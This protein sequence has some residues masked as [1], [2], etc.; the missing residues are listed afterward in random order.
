MCGLCHTQIDATGIYRRADYLAGGMRVGAYPHGTYVTYNLTSDVATGIGGWSG[1]QLISAFQDGRAPDHVLNPNLMIWVFFHAFTPQDATAVAT[2]LKSQPPVHNAIPLPLRYGFFETVLAKLALPLPAATPA[3]LTYREGN[4]GNRTDNPAG[5]Q[6][7]LIRLQWILLAMG[8]VAWILARPRGR[9]WPH[10]GRAWL[11][12]VA[13]LAGLA[14]AGL[15][16]SALYDLPALAVI[17][18]DQIAAGVAGGLWRPD[19]AKLATPEQRAL[20]ERGRYLY[21]VDSCLTC[22][23]PDGA[24]GMKISWRAGGS[25]WSRNLTSDEQTG[26]GA[27]TDEQIARAMRSGI[28]RDGRPL[29]WQMMIWDHVS[30]MDEEDVRAV[31][32]FLRTLP[33]STEEIHADTPPSPADCETY[34]FFLK[35]DSRPV[36]GCSAPE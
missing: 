26:L 18:P 24:G 28:S 19:P 9:R 31:I 30:N 27:W 11:W 32:A 1:R 10:G 15:L 22:H 35:P 13:L 25:F 33:P 6:G 23:L 21:A 17:P 3:G 4:F 20:V 16:G 7:T 12:T 36:P 2:Y 34:T 29:H 8:F 14:L 5:L